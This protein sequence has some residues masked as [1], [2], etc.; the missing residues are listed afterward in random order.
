TMHRTD[1]L[2]NEIDTARHLQLAMKQIVDGILYRGSWEAQN[3]LAPRPDD[4]YADTV[5]LNELIRRELTVNIPPYRARLYFYKIFGSKDFTDFTPALER[6]NP[7]IINALYQPLEEMIPEAT[8]MDVLI[9]TGYFYLRK[10][11]IMKSIGIFNLAARKYPG[12]SKPC[13]GLGDA[14]LASNEMEKAIK[15]Y[16]DALLRNPGNQTIRTKLE[17]LKKIIE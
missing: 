9:F 11:E 15:S 3:A 5:Y 6:E 4:L 1:H 10:K 2:G 8:Q 7:D 12:E 16:E 17:K 14:Y 13:D